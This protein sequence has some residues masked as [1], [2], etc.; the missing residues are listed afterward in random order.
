MVLYSQAVH[1]DLLSLFW[2]LATWQKHPLSYEH[3]LPCF[4]AL[5]AAAD[6]ICY[7]PLHV[8][9]KH[10]LLLPHGDYVHHYNHNRHIR[11]SIIYNWDALNHV[12]CVTKILHNF[13]TESLAAAFD[14]RDAPW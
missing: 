12:A 13:T 14:A 6:T 9:A 2:E 3:A 1:E 5:R 8:A 7:K 4:L 11:W 10:P